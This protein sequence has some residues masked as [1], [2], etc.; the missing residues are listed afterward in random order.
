MME[1][2]QFYWTCVLV[3]FKTTYNV[4][5]MHHIKFFK[6][7]FESIPDYRNIVLLMDSIEKDVDLLQKK[8]FL[9][10]IMFVFVKGLNLF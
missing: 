5:Q 8:C 9:Q 7:V 10:K 6:V 2:T 3:V 1:W 4:K